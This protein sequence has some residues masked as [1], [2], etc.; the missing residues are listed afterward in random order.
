M[1]NPQIIPFEQAVYGSFPF[2]DRGY[3]MLAHSPG[4]R[5]SWLEGFGLACQKY[6]EPTAGASANRAIFALKLP[7]GPNLIVG[8][9]PQ[10]PDDRGRP[11]ALAF[12][13]LFVD[14]G[15]MKR[16]R[17][18]P[19]ALAGALRG[20]WG[21][22][23][24]LTSE[25]WP[26]EIPDRPI[27]EG[28]WISQAL[29]AGKRVALESSEPIADL[30]R[31]AWSHLP[32]R[33]RKRASVATFAFGNDNRFD[34]VALPRL[35]GAA[36]DSSYVF[37]PPDPDLPI[38]H[39]IRRR[40]LGLVAI[41]LSI[42]LI[43]ALGV[44]FLQSGAT[45]PAETKVVDIPPPASRFDVS[46]DDPNERARVLEGLVDLAD[47]FGVLEPS[48]TSD[49]VALMATISDR[50]RYRG[51]RLTG[52]DLAAIRAEAGP[53]GEKALALDAQISHF[54]PDRPLPRDFARGSLRWQLDCLAWSF[55]VDLGPDRA[56]SDIPFAIAEAL[57]VP[58]TIRPVPIA[59]TY[60]ALA[61]YERFLAR[62]PRR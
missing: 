24:T 12:H 21:P 5:E 58:G 51:P 38:P 32:D 55:R 27:G 62:L 50:L 43:A 35:K 14:L 13:G 16:L 45:R 57:S 42:A 46:N 11:G 19:F 25:T 4:C 20:G 2:W 44:I 54:L 30:A 7:K 26:V 18:D 56:A 48:K 36:I 28:A 17:H 61:D 53:D 34:L 29:I 47:R 40:H 15:D 31:S 9:E 10:G 8:V 49:P 33:I 22:G 52:E 3:G 41:G 39:P 60:P 1:T 59:E 6:G 37:A 23:T